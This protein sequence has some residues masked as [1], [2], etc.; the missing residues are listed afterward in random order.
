M[1]NTCFRDVMDFVSFHGIEMHCEIGLAWIIE[2]SCTFSSSS[3]WNL[4]HH[5]THFPTFSKLSHRL[6]ELYEQYHAATTISSTLALVILL[7]C[8][9]SSKSF[10]VL[11][12]L[13]SSATLSKFSSA[14]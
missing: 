5:F 1:Y 11:P 12:C 8:P 2:L 3:N 6:S 9:G 10:K 7:K 14:N 4:E 13:I